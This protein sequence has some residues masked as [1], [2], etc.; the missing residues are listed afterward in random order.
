L[1]RVLLRNLWFPKPGWTVMTSSRSSSPIT[2]STAPSGVSGLRANPTFTPILLREDSAP[3]RFPQASTCTVMMS[4]PASTNLLRYFS[5]VSIM[6]WTLKGRSVLSLRQRITEGPTV[7]LGTK[8]PSITSQCRRSAPPLST[9]LISSSS[10]PKS[11]E[12][13]EGAIL[14]L[15][16][17]SS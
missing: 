11:A 5:G 2:P 15:I 14:I 1:G 7:R 8:C 6:R 12:R 13:R 9:S 3:L 16:S 4:P 10:L 17:P